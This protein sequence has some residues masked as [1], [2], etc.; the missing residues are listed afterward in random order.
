MKSL[1]VLGASRQVKVVA[2]TAATCG[3]TEIAFFDDA[4]PSRNANGSWPILGN[5]MELFKRLKEFS[6]GN[7]AVGDTKFLDLQARYA[8]IISLIHP[9]AFLNRHAR[10]GAG[11]VV[12]AGAVVNAAALIGRGATNYTGSSI[13]ND[14]LLGDSVHLSRGRCLAG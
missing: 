13:A 12:F 14:C 3:W 9:H 10:L 1:A 6:G 8:P 7:N 5:L 4:C 11:S 2:G